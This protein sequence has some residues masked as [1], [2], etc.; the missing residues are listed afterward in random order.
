MYKITGG[1]KELINKIFQG[2]S[3]KCFLE[4]KKILWDIDD[5][6]GACDYRFNNS[7]TWKS[8]KQCNEALKKILEHFDYIEKEIK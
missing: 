2:Y 1:K 5:C 7:Y 4:G 8:K 6:I 3:I